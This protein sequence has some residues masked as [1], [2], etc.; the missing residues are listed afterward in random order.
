MSSEARSAFLEGISSLEKTLEES[1]A[2]EDTPRGAFVRRGLTVASFNLLET[3][4]L[5]RLEEIAT[6]L[7]SGNLLYAELP[8]RLQLPSARTAIDVVSSR[9]RRVDDTERTR[10]AI[11]LSN[12]LSS[13]HKSTVSFSPLSW[14]WSGSNMGIDDYKSMLRKFHVVNAFAKVRDVA[15]RLGF[16]TTDPT[17]GTPLDFADQLNNLAQER[18]SSAHDSSHSVSTMWLKTVGKTL[19]Q[20]GSGFDILASVGAANLR[21]ATRG[22]FDDDEWTSIDR[23]TLHLVQER[24]K[25]FA[26]YSSPNS[27]ATKV[28]A[29]GDELFRFASRKG[30]LNDVVAR[31]D[32]NNRLEN[33]TVPHIG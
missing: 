2:V 20:F 15:D 29:D 19:L 25:D 31:L 5:E 8:Q 28:L 14:V 21:A 11:E 24:S 30:K 1:W 16:Q 12:T 13:M 4:V 6:Y 3:F 18:H 17:T 33:W 22:Y 7:N 26:L 27:K 23:V 10:L 9:L 32:R